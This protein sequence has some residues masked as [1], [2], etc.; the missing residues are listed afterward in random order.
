VQSTHKISGTAARGFAD[1]LT[2]SARRGDYYV[3][4]EL[5]GEGG[6]WH[7]AP[8]ALA[9]LGLDADRSVR[10]TDLVT[11]MEG[12]SPRTGEPIRRVGGDGSLVAGVDMTFSAPKSVSALWAEHRPRRPPSNRRGHLPVSHRGSTIQE[13]DKVHCLRGESVLLPDR[14]EFST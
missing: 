9:E 7:G 13:Q 3:G 14:S 8:D 11:S 5:E 1:Y 12:R 4:G 6:L 10:K 2:A